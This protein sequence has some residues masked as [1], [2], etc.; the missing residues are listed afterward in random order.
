MC[1]VEHKFLFS[2]TPD[3]EKNR[4]RKLPHRLHWHEPSHITL[5]KLFMS[6]RRAPNRIFAKNK[7]QIKYQQAARRFVWQT[8]C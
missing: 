2:F 8:K 1:R 5:K 7:P 6:Q 4:I 3:F